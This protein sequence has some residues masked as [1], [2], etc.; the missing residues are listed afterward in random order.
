MRNKIV[1][2]VRKKMHVRFNNNISLTFHGPT[3]NFVHCVFQS[4]C[5]CIQTTGFIISCVHTQS[6]DMSTYIIALF[7]RPK[8]LDPYY[9]VSAV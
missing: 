5:T 9:S 8:Y 2:E 3:E 1:G 6:T 7:N 4:L